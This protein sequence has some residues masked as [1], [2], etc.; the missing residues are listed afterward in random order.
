M[1]RYYLEHHDRVTPDADSEELKLVARIGNEHERA[2]LAELQAGSDRVASIDARALDTGLAET[3]AAIR[4]RT[5]I[6][7]QAAFVDDRFAGFSDFTMLGPNGRY[8]IWDTKLARAPKPYY[9]VQLCCY[10]E[11]FAATTGEPVPE[12]FGII[13]GSGE[14][15]QFRVEDFIH[16]YRR[17]RRSFLA[18]QDGFNANLDDCPEPLSGADHGRWTTHARRYFEERDHLVRVAGIS[19]G[20]IKKLRAAGITTMNGLA[21]G[22][23]ASI[24]RLAADTLDRLSAQARL[25]VRTLADR[26]ADP[27]APARYEV[28]TSGDRVGLGALPPANPSDVFFDMEGYP[29][30]AGGLEYLF[31]AYAMDT[32]TRRLKFYDWWAHTRGEEKVA[33]EAFVDWVFARWR[34]NPAMHVYHYAAYEMSALRRLS[35]R[36][37]TRQQEVDE[38]LRNNVLVDLFQI[39]RHGIRIGEP[40]YSI[41]TVERFYRAR[42]A[43]E[44]ATGA[45]SIVQYAGWIA[46][47]ESPDWTRSPILKSI[48]DYN[49]D[50]C[51]STA[52]LVVWLR[53][54]A[55]QHGVRGGGLGRRS[56]EVDAPPARELPPEAIRRQELSV[57]LQ[58][59]PDPISHRLAELV[60]FH[61]R[62]QKPMWWRMFD[63]AD[64]APDELRD[65]PGCIE[66]VRAVGAPSVEKQSVVQKY[67]FDPAQE[68]KL[69]AGARTQVLFAHNL[70]KMT[71]ASLDIERGELQLKIS[72]KGL[73]E[74]FGGRFPDQGSLLPDEFVNAEVIQG[75]LADTAEAHLNGSL[76]APATALLSRRAPSASLEQPGES[77]LDGAIRVCLAMDGDSLVVQGPPGTGKTYTGAHVIKALV[78]AG[79]TVGIASNSHKAIDNL[80][81]ACGEA[82]RAEGEEL[83]GIKVLGDD[84][85]RLF[86]ENPDLQYVAATKDAR[87]VFSSGV[88]GG[89]AW[90]FARPEWTQALD[91]LVIDEAGQVSL[92]N[93]VAMA[94]CARNIILLGD[95][96]QL[97]QPAQGVHPGDS[98]LSGLQYALKDLDASKPDAPI[99]HAVVPPGSGLFLGES[100]RMHPDVC[101]FISDSIYEGRL[102]SHPD[103]ER[104]HIELAGGERLIRKECGI[105]FSPI[106]HD[107]NIQRSDEER[108]RVVAI[109]NELAGRPYT[110]SDGTTRSLAPDDFLFIAPY[111]AQ[112]RSL[113]AVLPAGARVGSVDKLQGQQA[114]VCILS[115]CS[116]YGEYGARGLGF[117]LDRNRINVAISRAQCLAVVVADP[118][119]AS[120][121]AGSLAEMSLINLFC[122]VV[123]AGGN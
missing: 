15:A 20:Q 63:R 60:D 3:L 105:V 59:R 100:R 24:P 9:A 117:I 13:L 96:M 4:T 84:E 123:S 69:A 120:T 67:T 32:S 68:C 12:R 103:C 88:V 110:A 80:L 77:P 114:P 118:R 54:V 5:P 11:M 107:S 57:T 46:A 16:Y 48:R 72:R 87:A 83:K 64:A 34:E 97:E 91:Y 28:L 53:G 17:V 27:E 78:G 95:Q 65:D 98:G 90:L 7:Y 47:R 99:F 92:A 50:D 49:Q 81:I 45:Q 10:V 44:V 21:L 101:R 40:D 1:D 121:S 14:R 116:S 58:A 104:Q 23:G 61:R 89:T 122:K 37:D 66:G 18:L 42:R 33:F 25:Q 8:E 43:T 106:E 82:V 112:V 22:A 31:G 35:V 108:D 94:R 70:Q 102:A 19:V 30:V 74:K 51:R 52:E 39:V 71:L 85:G 93:V 76:G 75:A 115:L 113:Q 56:L 62:E 29:L 36:H 86:D 6:I 73:G 111:N 55:V 38:L 26:A 79:K 41:K 119:I 109:Y 2:V